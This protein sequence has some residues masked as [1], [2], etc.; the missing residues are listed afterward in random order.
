MSPEQERRYSVI[1]HTLIITI[2]CSSDRF[3]VIT[4]QKSNT[5]YQRYYL[6]NFITS[7]YTLFWH[8]CNTSIYIHNATRR[9]SQAV[10][11]HG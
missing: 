6:D 8:A 11:A 5:L 3:T 4:Y 2:Y 10:C 9:M 7:K 1:A